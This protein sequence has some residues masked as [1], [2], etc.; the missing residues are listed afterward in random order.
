MF[1]SVPK[2]EPLTI[3]EWD[4]LLKGQRDLASVS[5]DR[6]RQ[7][8]VE[9]INPDIRGQVWCLLCQFE[10]DRANHNPDLYQKLL[11]ME[12]HSQEYLI[13][14]DI[15]RTMAETKLFLA[16]YKTGTNPLFNVLK[17][18]TCYD[19]KVGYVQG[20]NYLAALLLIEIKDELKV[21]WC[22][23][24]LLF[25]RNWRMVYDEHTPKLMNML[26][27]IKD[28]LMKDDAPLL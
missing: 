14:K 5:K 19:N 24:T 11:D 8:I 21:F 22:L 18:Y 4:S 17:A 23:F 16:D 2:P 28:R 9:G 3:D 12:N 15:Y 26:A 7:S 25:R 6:L 1:L 10:L 20:M 13:S 27:L